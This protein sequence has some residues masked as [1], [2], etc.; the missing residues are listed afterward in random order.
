MCEYF[1]F[2]SICLRYSVFHLFS[3]HIPIT[4][5][6]SLEREEQIRK[7]NKKTDGVVI[8]IREFQTEAENIPQDNDKSKRLEQKLD[9]VLSNLISFVLGYMVSVHST[10]PK[11]N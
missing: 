7:I 10:K 2:L 4:T 11:K 8:A 9:D 6:I 1:V 3:E 5:S